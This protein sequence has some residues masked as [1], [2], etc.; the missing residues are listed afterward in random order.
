MGENIK[1]SVVG[2]SNVGKKT[3]VHS[4]NKKFFIELSSRR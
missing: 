4:F 3:F 1:I 2:S